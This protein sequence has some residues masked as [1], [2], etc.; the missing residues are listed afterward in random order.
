[1][2]FKYPTISD[3]LYLASIPISIYII[4][5]TL[6]IY[7]IPS[8]SKCSIPTLIFSVCMPIKYN[9]RIFA[10]YPTI[11][12]TLYLGGISI[13]ICIVLDNILPLSFAFLTHH[14]PSIFTTSDF[15]IWPVFYTLAPIQYH[16]YI[17]NL[18]V[19]KLA[20]S[21][22]I[23]G[24]FYWIHQVKAG[25]IWAPAFLYRENHALDAWFK[26]AFWR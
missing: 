18:Y 4:W 2:P 22:S 21:P 23:A 8:A 15:H 19:I 24:G 5:S 25:V 14:S 11:S 26:K 17:P 16:I 12:D 6:C 13:S 7:I 10:K 3:T 20:D 9:K 1:M